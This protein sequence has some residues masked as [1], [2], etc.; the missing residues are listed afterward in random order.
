MNLAAV[1]FETHPI[2]TWPEDCPRPVGVAIMLEGQAPEYLAWGHEGGGNNT[3]KENA[4]AQLKDL[5]SRHEIIY[6]NA[7]FDM[8]V[9]AR[10]LDLPYPATFHD[11][12]ILAFLQDPYTKALALKE[13]ADTLLGV[14]PEERDELREWIRTHIPGTKSASSR[15]GSFI[16]KTPANIASA[17]ACGDVRRTFGL[18]AFLYPR[19]VNAGMLAAYERELRLLP[20]LTRMTNAGIPIARHRLEAALANWEASRDQLEYEI[21]SALGEPTLNLNS[22]D[23]LADAL[24]AAGKVKQFRLTEKG[25]R[26]VSR[27]ALAATVTDA[28]LR[29][30]LN[31]R[32]DVEN[33]LKSGGPLLARSSGDGRIH[34]EWN[35][36]PYGGGGARTGR[37]ISSGPNLQGAPAQLRTFIIPEV[38]GV[39]LDRDFAQQ[40]LRVL[41]HFEN[42]QAK[43]QYLA[44][45]ITDFHDMASERA[46]V[47]LG[48][49][50][51]RKAAKI[52]VFSSLYGAGIGRLST[53]LDCPPHEAKTIYNAVFQG[54]P[55]VA[56][57]KRKMEHV[58]QFTTWG[59]RVYHVQVPCMVKGHLQS[60]ERLSLNTLIQ[61]SAADLT[62]TAM[63]NAAEAGLDLRLTI[64]DE[65]V[66]CSEPGAKFRRDMELLRQSMEDIE[67]S[68][69]MLSDGRWSGQSLGAL[70]KYRHYPVIKKLS[71]G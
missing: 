54:L 22:N 65:L 31:Q 69:P 42:G 29:A 19:I 68:I 37:I 58:R 32:T 28:N 55:D 12:M 57:F 40:E 10:H 3:T 38:G 48:R 45:P 60:Y 47:V 70:R 18:Y 39:W 30:L 49:T 20:I 14:R 23:Q 44:D 5:Y 50:I 61:G 62:K 2:G 6:Y 46:T 43:A 27:E 63:I 8:E 59:G 15:W 26:S 25:K 56:V 51:P 11:T 33:C 41:A 71:D 53:Q 67:F 9:G 17:Y 16:A 34:C 4:A 66:I 13:V 7:A 52:T 35:S 21:R 36:V 1:D 24:E 64:H